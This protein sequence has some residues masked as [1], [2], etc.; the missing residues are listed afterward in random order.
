M[1]SNYAAVNIKQLNDPSY[2]NTV[3]T[4]KQKPI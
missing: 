3:A 4:E 2:T 1:K